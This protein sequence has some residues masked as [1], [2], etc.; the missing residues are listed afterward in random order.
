MIEPQSVKP[1]AR[2]PFRQ[3]Q[4]KLRASSR[5]RARNDY[6]PAAYSFNPSTL[7]Y[8][9]KSRSVVKICQWRRYSHGAEQKINCRPGNPTAAAAMVHLRRF[10]VIAQFKPRT[11]EGPQIVPEL[12]EALF[13]A[14]SRK[15]LLPHHA[16]QLRSSIADQLGQRLCQRLFSRA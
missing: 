15:Q 7:P 13:L 9:S 14:D 1:M 12:L 6:L 2:A 16:H 3:A 10:F 8:R 11:I 5:P 4:D